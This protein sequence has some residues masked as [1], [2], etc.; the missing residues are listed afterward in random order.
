MNCKT[1]NNKN[2]NDME[3]KLIILGRAGFKYID[4]NKIEYFINSE[5]I[6]DKN[7]DFAVWSDSIEFYENHLKRIH[8]DNIIYS[9]TYDKKSK[10]Y[11]G[12]LEYK[13]KYPSNISEGKKKHIIERI[14]ALSYK[15]GVKLEIE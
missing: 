3:D 10:C 8:S 5:M 2:L 1:I 14:T 6:I 13:N 11:N 12:K 7:Y 4:E 9:E 15:Q